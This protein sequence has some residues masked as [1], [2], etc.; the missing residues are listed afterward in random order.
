MP[1][2]PVLV[3]SEVADSA[4]EDSVE[5]ASEVADYVEGSVVDS[6]GASQVRLLA[7]ISLAKISMPI[8]LVL[9]KVVPE[10]EASEWTTTTIR[11]D[12]TVVMVQ[13]QDLSPNPVSRLWFAMCVLLIKSCAWLMLTCF[14]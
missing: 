14:S 2:S 4:A 13:V 3:P 7:G 6:A 9:I 12:L 8:I 5:G 10:E 1:A 11:A